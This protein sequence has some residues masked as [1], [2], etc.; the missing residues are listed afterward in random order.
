MRNIL[1]NVDYI[2]TSEPIF[3]NNQNLAQFIL[4]CTSANLPIRINYCDK[5]A[6]KFFELSRGL[7]Y[8]IHK[9]RLYMLKG[10]ADQS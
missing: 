8:S 1:E 4:D 2:E 5:T 7:C 6:S 10:L 9:T 3:S